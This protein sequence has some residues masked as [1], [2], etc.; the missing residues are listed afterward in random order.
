MN[1]LFR[2]FLNGV[3][4]RGGDCLDCLSDMYGE[5]ART[6]TRYLSEI[7]VSGRLGT[8]TNCDEEREGVPQRVP[9]HTIKACSGTVT[10]PSALAGPRYRGGKRTSR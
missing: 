2:T 5:P 6:V 7:Q 9:G 3:S 8:C 10:S 4:A 1:N